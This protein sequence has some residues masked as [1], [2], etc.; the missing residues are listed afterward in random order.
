MDL[1]GRVQVAAELPIL[2]AQGRYPQAP[3]VTFPR[4][5]EEGAEAPRRTRKS[6]LESSPCLLTLPVYRYARNR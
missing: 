4:P 6:K 1:R 3:E 5:A 2:Y